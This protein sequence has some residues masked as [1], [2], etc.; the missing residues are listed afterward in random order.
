MEITMRETIFEGEH[1]RFMKKHFRR[2][3]GEGIWETI[4]R[5]N[6]YNEGA[7]VIIALTKEGDLILERNWR[8]PLESFVIQFPAGLSD[9]EGE[10]S[11]EVARRELLE[12]TGYK[13]QKLIPIIVTP[14]CPAL[15]PTRA[16]HFFAP[17]VEFIGGESIE[18]A[19]EIEVLKVPVNNLD[20]FLMNLPK[21]TELDLRVPGILWVLE[22]KKLI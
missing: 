16:A 14:L 3:K 4:E 11:E 6:V 5:K 10:N 17:E 22:R 21:D 2:G 19:E 20:D 18:I 9:R 8:A 13:A 12:E 15:T 1:L 7:V